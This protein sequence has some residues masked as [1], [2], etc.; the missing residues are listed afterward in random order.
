MEL[1]LRE[2]ASGSIPCATVLPTAVSRLAR[3]RLAGQGGRWCT[4]TT[5]STN[6]CCETLK[7]LSAQRDL[8]NHL[9]HMAR[10]ITT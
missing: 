7:K 5:S 2:G 1:S 9:S 6:S 8:V 4:V 3:R 10:M